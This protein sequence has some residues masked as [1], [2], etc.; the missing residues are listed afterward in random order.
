MR[1]AYGLMGGHPPGNNTAVGDFVRVLQ[2]HLLVE[3]WIIHTEWAHISVTQR[4]EGERRSTTSLRSVELRFVVSHQERRGDH[5][6]G[7]NV[8]TEL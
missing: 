4:M 7:A 5:F 6:R 3:V 8:G 1:A 2:H